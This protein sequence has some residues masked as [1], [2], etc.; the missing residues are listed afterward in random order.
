M[1]DAL[2]APAPLLLQ[3]YRLARTAAP[4]Q[5]LPQALH[6]LRAQIPFDAA[7][8]CRCET[9]RGHL[10][11]HS[12]CLHALPDGLITGYPDIKEQDPVAAA[13]TRQ[14]GT[15]HTFDP[16]D[17]RWQGHA[18]AQDYWQ[19]HGFK[20]FHAI[21]LPTGNASNGQ[22][23]AQRAWLLALLSSQPAHTR[24]RQSASL[25]PLLPH[26]LES[27]LFNHL[28]ALHQAEH[29]DIDHHGLATALYCPESI[30]YSLICGPDFDALLKAEFGRDLPGH[31]IRHLPAPLLALAKAASQPQPFND[32]E[33][34]TTQKENPARHSG[35]QGVFTFYPQ[36]A[37]HVLI[38]GRR[39][40][41]IDTLTKTELA[42][43]ELTAKGLTYKE[44]ARERWISPNT[45]RN[46]LVNIRNKIDAFP[47]KNKSI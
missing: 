16:E 46:H 11:I 31:G 3:L 5:F 14:P 38:H 4:T 17:S 2:H 33:A 39:K 9:S 40:L 45:V 25:A 43:A 23:T 21:A 44:I 47:N 29:V 34:D 26:L 32:S 1:P 28:W 42:I 13:V 27:Q 37:G 41:P 6:A 12:A 30:G 7:C 36:P 35:K 24:Q 8:L 10:N 19:Q 20:H 15:V 18:A 22:Q